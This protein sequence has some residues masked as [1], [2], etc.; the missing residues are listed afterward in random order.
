MTTIREQ[1]LSPRPSNGHERVRTTLLDRF[2]RLL[3]S[4][5]VSRTVLQF[6]STALLAVI[7]IGVAALVVLRGAGSDQS[8]REAR[9]ITRL[10]A[11]GVV[12]PSLRDGILRQDPQAIATLDAIVKARVL[13]S[14]VVRVKIWSPDGRIVYSDEQRLIGERFSL[15]GEER[16]V[17]A[18]GTVA[19]E[20]SDLTRPENRFERREGKLLEVYLPV[21]T[22]SG[23]PLLFESYMRFSAVEASGREVWLAFMPALV[24]ALLLLWLIQVPLAWAFARR[25]EHGRRERERLLE[26]AVHASEVERRRIASDLHDGVVQ[27][28]AGITFSLASSAERERGSEVG[29]VLAEA[30]EVTRQSMRR[31]RSLLVEIYPPS[32][33]AAGLQP[34][35]LDLLAPLSPRG[36]STDLE[37]PD[38][39]RLEPQLEQ[40][41]FRTA[42]EA[43]RNAVAHARAR[44]VTVR[45]REAGGHVTLLVEDDGVGFS[46]DEAARRQREGHV[47]LV[48][49]AGLAADAGGRLDVTSVPGRGTSVQLE[50]QTP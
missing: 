8:I 41:F 15:G 48:A 1:E 32:L 25:L 21:H 27:D 30:A 4:G 39:L 29:P 34:A 19:A 37:M 33:E 44:H 3:A 16:D 13:Q 7:V 18:D 43:L 26:R 6:A 47:G 50:V 14:P 45:I 12:E 22:P 20:I 49:L 35:L 23:Q 17:L 38:G 10:L 31:L 28:L 11:T 36:I 5:S 46:S 24:G 2:D 42:Q 40:L 9:S